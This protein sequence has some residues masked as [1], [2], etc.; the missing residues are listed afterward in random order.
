M[1]VTADFKE[2]DDVR[3]NASLNREGNSSDDKLMM[4]S[5]DFRIVM[6]RVN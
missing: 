4:M 5:Q 3:Q 1:S 2:L 6:F